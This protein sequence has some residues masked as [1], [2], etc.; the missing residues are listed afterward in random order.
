MI[1]EDT[2][3]G[4]D[5]LLAFSGGMDSA[6]VLSSLLEDKRKVLCVTFLYGSKHSKQEIRGANLVCQHYGVKKIEIGLYPC[7]TFSD[8]SL[9]RRD[10]EIPH[11]HY[12]DESMK[13]TIVPGRN[14]IFISTLAGIALAKQIPSI[15]V[16]CHQGDHAIYP[17][18][19][20][21]YLFAMREAVWLGSGKFVS[22][23]YPFI[24]HDKTTIVQIGTRMRTPYSL[25]RTCYT[26]QPLA[27]GRC[28]S[29][30]E[31]LEAFKN[32]GFE[33]PVKYS[34]ISLEYL[35]GEDYTW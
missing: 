17:D 29:C 5:T 14:G 4:I 31:R 28:G 3:D 8:S 20:E 21:D 11:G 13:S 7:F 32:N 9:T 34:F 10:K 24:K 23:E 25:T 1:K 15:V 6:T 30:T 19:T 26:D 16:G 12:E 27:C 35:G 22:L 2:F 18:C 33:D